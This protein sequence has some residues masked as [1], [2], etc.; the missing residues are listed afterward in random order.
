MAAHSSPYWEDK[1][2]SLCFM[3]M[4]PDDNLFKWYILEKCWLEFC[5]WKTLEKKGG[6]PTMIPKVYKCIHMTYHDDDARHW[7]CFYELLTPTP[8]DPAFTA[9]LAKQLMSNLT[10]L[11]INQCTSISWPPWFRWF[12]HRQ[13]E[14]K[15]TKA[16]IAANPI[17]VC[18]KKSLWAVDKKTASFLVTIINDCL[19]ESPTKN[20]CGPSVKA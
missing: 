11:S 3:L 6:V 14:E 18:C 2:S 8:S 20:C 15:Q 19:E 1:I 7:A 9:S 12:I 5:L 16:S 17:F 13:R 10:F 4:L